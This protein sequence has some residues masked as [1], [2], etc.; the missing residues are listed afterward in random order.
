MSVATLPSKL[1]KKYIEIQDVEQTFKTP[2]KGLLP[3]SARHQPDGCQGRVRGTHRSFRLRQIHPAEPDRRPDACPTEGQPDL[4]QSS[5]IAGPGPERA[6][7]FQ[8]H[9]LL[10]W[11]TCFENV[12]LGVERVFGETREGGVS[13]ESKAQLQASAPMRRIGPGGTDSRRAKAA[14]RNL[15]RHEAARRHR[16]RAGDGA[17]GAAH[18]RALRRAGCPHPRPPAGRTAGHRAEDAK[19][20]GDGD[21]R[22]GRG[23]AAV[24][25]ASS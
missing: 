17:Q 10:P 2:K 18:G 19:H 20:R 3:R 7:V 1:D 9:S 25:Q 6:V 4:R 5:E 8:N 14:W 15:R 24:G 11:L 23:G 22:C 16:T 21:A 13:A 12:Y